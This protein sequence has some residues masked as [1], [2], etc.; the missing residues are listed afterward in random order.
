MDE[1]LLK[2]KAAAEVRVVHSVARRPFGLMRCFSSVV[3]LLPF[4]LCAR[5]WRVKPPTGGFCSHGVA[6]P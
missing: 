4:C 1:G 6:A 2:L 5:G 3:V